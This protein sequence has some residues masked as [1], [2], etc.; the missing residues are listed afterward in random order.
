MDIFNETNAI[1]LAAAAAASAGTAVNG[2]AQDA[3]LYD[4]VVFFATVATANAGNFLK[5]QQGDLADGSDAADLEGSKVVAVANGQ[6]VALVVHK[7]KKRY[8]RPVIIRA[9][10]NT[11]TGDVYAIRYRAHQAPVT[12]DV[13]NVLI[14]KALAS[15]AEGTP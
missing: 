1:R 11:A 2:T 15:P 12:N 3:S 7:P 6:V 13:L 9:G 5:A 8:V 14:T 10:A 4:G